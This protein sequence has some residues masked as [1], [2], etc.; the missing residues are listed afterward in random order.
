[1]F[2]N[3]LLEPKQ[4]LKLLETAVRQAK[5]AVLITS[6]RLDPPGPQIV[7]VNPAFSEMTGYN[8]EEILDKTPRIL[9]GP[10]SDR[11]MLQRLR[12]ALARGEPFSGETVN[13]RK[14]G[15]EYYV[16][17]DI[18]PI[19]D[20]AGQ[21]KH[22]LSIQRNV[23]ERKSAENRLRELLCQIER[24]RNDLDSILN[25]LLIGAVMADENGRVV[26]TNTAARHLFA[27]DGL[28]VAWQDLFGLN[29]EDS[30]H[31]KLLT[32]KPA[33][34]RG[35]I[36]LHFDRSDGRRIW[37]EVD[38]KDDPRDVRGKIFFLYDV[39]E[40]HDLRRLLDHR[41]HFHDLL[42]KSKAMQQV[43]Q[44]IRDLAQVDATVLI[45]GETGTGKELVA[46]A[47]HAS[48]HRKD[49]PF[50]AVNCAGL[51][52]SLLSSQL[53]GHKRGAFTGAIDDQQG[54][55]EAA[56]RGTLL[57]D[58]IGDIPIAVQNQLLRVLQEREIVR[59]GESRPR[60]ID[61]RVLAATHRNLSDEA[62]KGNFRSD[63]FYR[64]RVARITLPPLRDRREDIPLLTAS[65]LAQLSAASGKRV[66]E[67]SD[68][69]LRLLT[70]Y[71]W[72]GNVRELRSAIEFAVIRC[73]GTVIQAD[74]LPPEIFEPAN[75]GGV[76]RDDP[77][78]DERAR[79][80]DA[81]GRSRGNRARAARLLGIS[82]AT[83]YRRLSD[84]K[85]SPEE[86]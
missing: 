42:G 7:F 2:E 54:F 37:L 85:I 11:A 15:G 49:K 84:L 20:S 68:D 69:A 83:L 14:D 28:G 77:S 81:L 41:A 12:E 76:V 1:M 61:V 66:T 86:K 75:L 70:R 5:E 27:T 38:V 26:F 45:E 44:Q 3:R 19:R 17:W 30:H 47:I 67:V 50:I 39:T 43:Y 71:P 72:P 40:V 65:F 73:R 60:K 6:A 62:A 23:T 25:A 63:L 34:E 18:T 78:S 59:L 55:L 24:S 52:E 36:P 57:L 56:N 22:F 35:R 32:Q 13:Y 46:R 4:L 53:F 21:I 29:S 79:L 80:L 74:D 58:E 31:F 64:I 82:R 33:E 9:Q 10:K 48:S 16:E 51:T 8:Q